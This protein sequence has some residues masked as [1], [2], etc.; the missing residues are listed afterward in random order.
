MEFHRA[1]ARP[2]A[3]P[4][5]V[6]SFPGALTRPRRSPQWSGTTAP[7]T[8]VGRARPVVREHPRLSRPPRRPEEQSPG[9]PASGLQLL[10][11]SRENCSSGA[12]S[13]RTPSRGQVP[14]WV[15]SRLAESPGSRSRERTAGGSCS[16]ALELRPLEPQRALQLERESSGTARRRPGPGEGAGR[17]RRA[18]P[19]ASERAPA[20][21]RARLGP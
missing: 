3:V 1:G 4:R 5:S 13:S 20:L 10:L 8:T 12:L 7:P 15:K 17:P 18:Q 9:V 21:S 2:A 11:S 14:Y 16:L 6:G 19:S